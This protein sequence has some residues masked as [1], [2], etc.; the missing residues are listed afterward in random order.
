MKVEILKNGRTVK[1]LHDTKLFGYVV[2]KGFTSDFAS[3]PR[4]LWNMFPPWGQSFRAAVVHDHMYAT[5]YKTK[6]IADKI[7][8]TN[9][10]RSGVGYIKAKAMYRAVRLFGRGSYD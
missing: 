8:Y 4:G 10:R 6:K 1:L 9:L 7:F 2:P 5:A 3:V